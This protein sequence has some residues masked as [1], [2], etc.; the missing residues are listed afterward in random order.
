MTQ[1]RKHT[2]RALAISAGARPE[3]GL[4]HRGCLDQR[5]CVAFPALQAKP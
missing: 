3:R 5:V 4:G 2:S 1:E